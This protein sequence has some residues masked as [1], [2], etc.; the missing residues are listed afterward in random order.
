MLT[1]L[2]LRNPK[3]GNP[4]RRTLEYGYDRQQGID[5]H[6]GQKLNGLRTDLSLARQAEIEAEVYAC[7]F[8]PA[9]YPVPA[10][11]D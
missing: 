8:I 2:H 6:M 7:G 1:V 5:R 10:I 4:Y 11:A 3:T 9:N